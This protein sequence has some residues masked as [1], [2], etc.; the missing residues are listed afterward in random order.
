MDVLIQTLVSHGAVFALALAICYLVRS[1]KRAAEGRGEGP[2]LMVAIYQQMADALNEENVP[3]VCA[4]QGRWLDGTKHFQFSLV[5]FA[6]RK[7]WLKPLV[8]DVKPGR[9]RSPV[10]VRDEAGAVR[11]YG[12]EESEVK[13]A[14]ARALSYIARLR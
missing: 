12:L 13:E 10:E 1:R 9:E 14:L 4:V 11:A 7:L 5:P 8:I 6:D 2:D 3:P